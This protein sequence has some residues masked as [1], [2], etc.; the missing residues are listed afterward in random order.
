MPFIE[1]LSNH[2]LTIAM[3]LWGTLPIGHQVETSPIG[4]YTKYLPPPPP[5]PPTTKGIAQNYY[6][7]YISTL[8]AKVREYKLT[9]RGNN[10]NL[11]LSGGDIFRILVAALQN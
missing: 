2:I 8:M 7:I 10:F 11:V 6:G 4:H 1:A 5:P 3:V 9:F